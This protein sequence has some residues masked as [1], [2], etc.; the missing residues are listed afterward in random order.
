[1]ERGLI[2][3]HLLGIGIGGEDEERIELDKI[4]GIVPYITEILISSDESIDEIE[5][6]E[7]EFYDIDIKVVDR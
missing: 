1:M 6:V 5:R 4:G 2:I 7:N 3:Y